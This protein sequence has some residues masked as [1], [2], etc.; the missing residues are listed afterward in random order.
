[1][2]LI[3]IRTIKEINPLVIKKIASDSEY[4]KEEAIFEENSILRNTPVPFPS[5]YNIKIPVLASGEKTGMDSHL[6]K[7]F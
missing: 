1:M 7:H 3:C 5:F 6:G 2:F 4:S